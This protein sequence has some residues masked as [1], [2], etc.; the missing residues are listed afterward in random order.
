MALRAG[1]YGVKGNLLSVISKLG[2]AKI[3]KTIGDGLK[4]TTAGKLSCDID[5]ETMEFKNGK[6]AAKPTGYDFS[7]DEVDTGQKWIDGKSIYCKVIDDQS[8]T[9]PGGSTFG[10]IDLSSLN[11]DTPVRCYVSSSDENVYPWVTDSASNTIGIKYSN[12]ILGF[13][14]SSTGG[15]VTVNHIRAILWYTKVTT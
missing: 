7:T 8:V 14:K 9:V 4:L 11:I 13:R 6:L 15:S 5:A 12:S 3:I 10:T 2:G 1:Y